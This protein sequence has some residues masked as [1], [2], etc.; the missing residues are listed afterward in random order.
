MKDASPDMVRARVRVKASARVR[1]RTRVR[2]RVRVGTRRLTAA[3][4]GPS[5]SRCARPRS[6]AH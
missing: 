6:R 5:A 2:V 4:G 1:V 3:S